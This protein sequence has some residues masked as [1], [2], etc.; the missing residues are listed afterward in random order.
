MTDLALQL[1]YAGLFFITFLSSTIFPF[2]SELV[3]TAMPPLGY[4]LWLVIIVAMTGS[5]LGN[6]VN[7][8]VGKKG[9]DFVFARYVSIKPERWA[10]AES[11]FQRWGVYSLFFSW[12]PVVGD[13][14]TVVA[15]ALHCDLRIFTF[16]VLTGKLVRYLV[17]FGVLRSLF[18]FF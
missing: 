9:T 14:L 6:L 3:V 15:G 12:L 16:W 2:P 1:G 17:F 8:Y 11:Y 10:Q 7:Y 13:P 18:D 5:F 4:N